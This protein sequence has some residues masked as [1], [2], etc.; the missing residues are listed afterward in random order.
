MIWRPTNG[1]GIAPYPKASSVNAFLPV[2]WS[3]RVLTHTHADHLWLFIT[4]VSTACAV[5]SDTECLSRRFKS[6][7][8]DFSLDVPAF[9]VML[10][11]WDGHLSGYREPVWSLMEEVLLWPPRPV[12]SRLILQVC[13]ALLSY[14]V[15]A[16][17]SC[18]L[19]CIWFPHRCMIYVRPWY[20]CGAFGQCGG[21]LYCL[22]G[23]SGLPFWS[24]TGFVHVIC[25]FLQQGP[26]SWLGPSGDLLWLQ[27]LSLTAVIVFFFNF[28]FFALNICWH[29]YKRG[30]SDR[31]FLIWSQEVRN[32]F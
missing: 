32:V 26:A 12:F 21:I 14:C 9:D 3:R 18:Q 20:S 31:P 17:K 8:G 24:W 22:P 1:C 28:F 10:Q 27:T 6:V 30:V 5:I 11:D 19:Y 25:C 15:H 16:G 7:S 29:L 23:V 13:C 2:C 4:C